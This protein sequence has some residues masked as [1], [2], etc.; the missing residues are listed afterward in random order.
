M[1]VLLLKSKTKNKSQSKN[2]KKIDTTYKKFN[3][4]NKIEFGNI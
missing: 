3:I 1:I 4:K 2:K